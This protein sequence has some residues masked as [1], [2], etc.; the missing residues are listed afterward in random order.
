MLLASSSLTVEDQMAEFE[1]VLAPDGTRIGFRRVG[2]GRPLV[3][4]HG[5]SAD[6]QRWLAISD[7]LARGRQLVMMDRR[8]RGLSGD[9]A[10]YD[11]ALEF[12]DVAAVIRAAVDEP[13]VLGHSFGALCALEASRHVPEIRRLIL[14]EPVFGI[15]GFQVYESDTA[16]M[17]QDLLVKN[18]PDAMLVHFLIELVGLRPE[19][20]EALR[21]GPGWSGRVAA[22]PTII[23]EMADGDFLFDPQNYMRLKMPCL[24]LVGSESPPAFRVGNERLA[25]ILPHAELEV[26]AGQG[27]AAMLTA[28][29]LFCA[30]VL[31]FLDG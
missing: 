11:I 18:G 24:L 19:D 21:A 1:H 14:Y 17:L 6:H 28:P 25:S 30:M 31:R 3:L 15:P 2:S 4:V 16:E 27:H 29:E 8:G 13:D 22:A 5:S 26:L 23:R 12:E 20:V 10:N 9:G 7:R